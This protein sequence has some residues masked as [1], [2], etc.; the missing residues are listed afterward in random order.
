MMK[1]IICFILILINILVMKDA[2]AA[3]KLDTYKNILIS[4]HYTIRYENITPAPRVTNKDKINLFGSSGM[5]IRQ[6]E[7]LINKSKSGIVV[8]NGNDRYEE[9]GDGNF[10]M[11]RLTK[12][13]ENFLFTKYVK[14]NRIEYYG[15]KKNKVEANAR[16]YLAE[17]IEGQSYGDADMSWLLNAMLPDNLKS[18]D[19]PSY[20]YAASGNL[21]NG[22]S[23]EDYKS[24]NSNELSA[25]RYYFKGNQLTKISAISYVKDG[26][27]NISGRKCII[28]INEF[29]STPNMKF[30]SLPAEIEDVT[31]RKI[32]E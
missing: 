4:K 20:I 5:S 7:Y 22:L 18:A 9:V 23:Y 8:G 32:K 17:I 19:M 2:F 6:N 31:N 27:N 30:L 3:T 12:N 25:I 15:N 26:S 11:C 29:S 21:N 14:G 28:K 16:N 1:R 13:N 10:N 24:V